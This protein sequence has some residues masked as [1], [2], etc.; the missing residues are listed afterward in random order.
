M[1]GIEV[2]VEGD[3][4]PGDVHLVVGGEYAVAQDFLVDCYADES[5]LDAGQAEA[6]IRELASVGMD[7]GE[8]AKRWDA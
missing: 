2:G 8:G 4:V 5:A 6:L 7:A 3:V 1:E